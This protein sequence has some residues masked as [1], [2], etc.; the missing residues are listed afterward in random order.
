MVTLTVHSRIADMLLKEEEHVTLEL[1][2]NIKKRLTI[3]PTN[4]LHIEKYELTWQN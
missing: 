2:R 3:I 1:E 4:N